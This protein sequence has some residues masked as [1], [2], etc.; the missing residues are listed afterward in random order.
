MSFQGR[1]NKIKY[2]KENRSSVHKHF[3]KTGNFSGFLTAT[4][5]V[6]HE[7]RKAGANY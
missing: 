3:N 4:I 7:T 5:F 6:T 2:G 1:R